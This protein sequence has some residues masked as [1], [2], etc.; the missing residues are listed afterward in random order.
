MTNEQIEIELKHLATKEDL[1]VIHTDIAGL[2]GV[3]KSDLSDLRAEMYKALAGLTTTIWITQL[4]A[5]GLIL[6]GVGL[7]IHFKV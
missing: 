3:L 2:R 6:V 7:L 5:T 4:S 1:A